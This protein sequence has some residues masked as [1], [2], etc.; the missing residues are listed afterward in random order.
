[1]FLK[2]IHFS[3]R[4]KS[5]ASQRDKALLFHDVIS[6]WCS[7]NKVKYKSNDENI[8]TAALPSAKQLHSK[9]GE[10]ENEQEKKKQEADDGTHTT[11]E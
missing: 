1:M 11:Q 5:F 8:N 3:E 2:L 7:L 9:K 4:E 6:F 10:Y